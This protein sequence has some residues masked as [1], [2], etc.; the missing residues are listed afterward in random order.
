[1]VIS[2]CV[3]ANDV[4]IKEVLKLTTSTVILV[5]LMVARLVQARLPKNTRNEMN[6]NESYFHA[7]LILSISDSNASA[8]ALRVLLGGVVKSLQ[9]VA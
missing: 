5:V 1:M 3:H 9:S 2:K 7:A 8:A 4:P 6:L